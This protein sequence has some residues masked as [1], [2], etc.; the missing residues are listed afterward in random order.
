MLPLFLAAVLVLGWAAAMHEADPQFVTIPEAELY[1][2]I[3]RNPAYTGQSGRG[4]MSKAAIVPNRVIRVPTW[5]REQ[6]RDSVSHAAGTSKTMNVPPTAIGEQRINEDYS[7][8]L[9][10][11]LQDATPEILQMDVDLPVIPSD[12]KQILA[13]RDTS[14]GRLWGPF[15]IGANT[16]SR[17]AYPLDLPAFKHLYHSEDV[18]P[19]NFEEFLS[20]NHYR[21]V[22]TTFRPEPSVL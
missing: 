9:G 16:F 1:P 20:G 11:H 7:Q 14:S 12:E 10:S 19:T 4:G 21:S 8:A 17:Q 22:G 6:D 15:R 13:F 5:P 3:D 18:V 2:V